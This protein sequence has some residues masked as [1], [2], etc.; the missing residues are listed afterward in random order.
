MEAESG[1]VLGRTINRCFWFQA[2][3]LLHSPQKP[4][5]SGS[6]NKAEGEQLKGFPGGSV[7][8]NPL[9]NAGDA[10]LLSGS[11]RFPWRR[12]WQP[13]PGFLPGKSHG[14]RSLVGY[15]PR[16]HKKVGQDLVTKQQQLLGPTVVKSEKQ[17]HFHLLC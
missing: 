7:V 13:I 1:L 11:G 5:C 17:K 15:I 10:G 2:R 14:Q 9:A 3:W 6:R 16:S 8:K 4:E 12:K